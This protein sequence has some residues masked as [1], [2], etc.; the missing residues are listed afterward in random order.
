MIGLFL[1]KQ[2]KSQNMRTL[3]GS[4]QKGVNQFVTVLAR[5]VRKAAGRHGRPM[6]Q[7][8][9]FGRFDFLTRLVL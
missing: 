1:P 4:S 3:T 9:L 7:R 5:R 8:E 2:D 6:L